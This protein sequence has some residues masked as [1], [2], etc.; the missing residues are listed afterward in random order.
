MKK[1]IALAIFLI[2]LFFNFESTAHKITAHRGDVKDGYNY[3]FAEPENPTELKP[4]V[5]FLH[6]QSLCGND[7]NKVKRYGTLDALEK[8][9]DIDAFVLAPQNP[10]GSWNPEKIMN[11]V[12]YLVDHNDKID[13]NRIYVLGMSL[14]GYGTLDFAATYADEIAAAIAMCGGATQK[15][16][17]TLNEMPLWIIH[18]TADNA[19]SI[20]Q[21]DKVV[22][23]MRAANSRTPRLSYDR[24]PGMNHSQPARVFY[25][26][27]TY[28]WLFSHSLLDEGRPITK[29]FDV[30]SKMS[31]A[32]SGLNFSGSKNKSSANSK[33]SSTSKKS[34]SKKSTTKKSG[35]KKSSGSSKSL[36]NK[37]K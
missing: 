29:T 1:Y 25:M 9:R 16:V 23:E 18:G 22:N 5:I 20:S 24:V 17:G 4:L 15:N 32:Y 11:I 26:P 34:G 8:G 31:G 10:G 7:L 21:S 30:S 33:S 37:K 2:A 12:D 28:E 36:K 27:E 14:G 13:Q 19:V 3:W 35:S 6:G